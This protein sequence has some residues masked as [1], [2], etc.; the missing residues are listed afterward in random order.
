MKEIASF[1]N[2]EL[3]NNKEKINFINVNNYINPQINII[4][5]N[6][7]SETKRG[8]NNK[9]NKNKLINKKKNFK[10]KKTKNKKNKNV[11]QRLETYIQSNH[12]QMQWH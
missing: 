4:K 3:K 8:I 5:V 12:L 9:D 6:K 7:L 10:G 11:H 2:Q 1:K